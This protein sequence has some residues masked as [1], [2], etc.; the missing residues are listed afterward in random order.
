MGT[1]MKVHTGESMRRQKEKMP[2]YRPKR[3]ALG[4]IKVAD[5]F[6]SDF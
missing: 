1:D 5:I 6:I 2:R 3:E 4:K